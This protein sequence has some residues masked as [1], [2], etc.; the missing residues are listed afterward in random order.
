VGN[1]AAMLTQGFRSFL[2]FMPK[3]CCE[4]GNWFQLDRKGKVLGEVQIA[5][6]IT[7]AFFQIESS[8]DVYEIHSEVQLCNQ[9]PLWATPSCQTS[10]GSME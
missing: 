9:S 1:P 6:A 7:E 4:K 3:Y 8:L 10:P 5:R 2:L